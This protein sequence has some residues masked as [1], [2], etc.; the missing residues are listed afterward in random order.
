VN[1]TQTV[2]GEFGSNH[3]SL[4]NVSRLPATTMRIGRSFISDLT[5]SDRGVAI[6]RAMLAFAHSL[7]L[8]CIAEGVET[9]E[10]R[11]ILLD[12]GCDEGDGSLFSDP[13]SAEATLAI[14]ERP[15]SF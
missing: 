3:A 13:L 10:Q 8:R 1:A 15:A 6:A 5:I 2:L 4:R 9:E 7:G 12:L 11:A 14:L